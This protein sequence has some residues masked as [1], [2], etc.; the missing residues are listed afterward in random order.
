MRG[1]FY[2]SLLSHRTVDEK[3][4][5][6]QARGIT[7]AIGIGPER[8]REVLLLTAMQT[9]DCSPTLARNSGEGS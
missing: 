8:F 1:N 6:Y 9:E 4:L 5:R 3:N 2:A 7:G